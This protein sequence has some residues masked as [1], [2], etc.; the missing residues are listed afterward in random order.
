[1]IYQQHG[2]AKD[3]AQ[4][5]LSTCEFDPIDPNTNHMVNPITDASGYRMVCKACVNCLL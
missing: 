5:G 3:L 1:M 2:P 4:G